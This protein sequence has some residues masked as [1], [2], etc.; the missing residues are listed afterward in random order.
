ML[1]GKEGGTGHCEDAGN[2][3]SSEIDVGSDCSGD[4]EESDRLRPAGV[5]YCHL[6]ATVWKTAVKELPQQFC[7]V[8]CSCVLTVCSVLQ[9]VHSSKVM[10]AAE[11]KVTCTTHWKLWARLWHRGDHVHWTYL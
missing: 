1:K 11:Q 8:W 3:E 6:T 5:M 7:N 2:G 10:L 9:A 4:V